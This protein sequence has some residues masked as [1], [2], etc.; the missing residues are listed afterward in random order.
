MKL[1]LSIAILFLIVSCQKKEVNTDINQNINRDYYQLKIYTLQND[2]QVATTDT[3]LK[4]SYIPS[5]KKYGIKNIGVFKLRTSETDTIQK[6]V[7][8]TPFS[9]LNEIESLENKLLNDQSYLTTGAAYINANHDNPPYQRVQ[10][11]L[12]KAFEDMPVLKPS[13]LDGPREDRIYE[14]RSYLSS[15]EAIYRNKVDMFNAGGEINLFEKLNFNAVFYGEVISGPNMPN[16]M[17]MTTHKNQETR[18][19]NWKNFGNSSEWKEMSSL[20]KYQNNVSH[21]DIDFLYPTEYS[22]Y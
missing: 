6:I 22:D 21:I 2:E 8:L 11:I 15:T 3:Y 19:E 10:T 16:L 9:S 1:K 4:Q 5:S 7:V 17:Y 13:K 20:E 12:L 14:L 18:D